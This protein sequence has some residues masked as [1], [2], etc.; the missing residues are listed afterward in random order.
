MKNLLGLIFR[1]ELPSNFIASEYQPSKIE[2]HKNGKSANNS[3]YE[4]I[5]QEDI[6]EMQIDKIYQS[7]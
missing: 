4:L 5:N 6:D 1:K 7:L 2:D 3:E